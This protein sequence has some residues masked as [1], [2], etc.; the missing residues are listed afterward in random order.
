MRE[1]AIDQLEATLRTQAPGDLAWMCRP[2]PNETHLTTW[3]KGFWDGMKFSYGGYY[4][5]GI[6][7]KPMNG[8]ILKDRPFCVW[9]YKGRPHRISLTR[10]MARNPP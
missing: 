10:S 8:I 1:M 3:I 6:G 2:Y 5:N 7:F 4:A 9:C